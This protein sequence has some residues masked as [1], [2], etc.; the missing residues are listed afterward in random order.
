MSTSQAVFFLIC[1]YI[2]I[3]DPAAHGRGPRID[4]W[5]VV[6]ERGT[7]RSLTCPLIKCIHVWKP[8]DISA[9]KIHGHPVHLLLWPNLAWQVMYHMFSTIP[10]GG[11]Q[12]NSGSNE[13]E[14]GRS[15]DA[16]EKKIDFDSDIIASGAWTCHFSLLE[17]VHMNF[18]RPRIS[19]QLRKSRFA[20]T[21]IWWS[22][23]FL[24]FYFFVEK[25]FWKQ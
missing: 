7:N 6:S 23:V 12:T 13:R 22:N 14:F 2:L 24:N 5:V 3:L 20:A 21:K 1:K 11:S 18:S 25:T 17:D 19:T 4:D 9:T 15:Q 16:V 10:R 8:M